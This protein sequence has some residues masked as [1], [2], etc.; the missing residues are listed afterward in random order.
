MAL[1]N[2]NNIAIYLGD[3][4]DRLFMSDES[5]DSL[6]KAADLLAIEPFSQLRRITQINSIVFPRQVHGTAGFIV[7]TNSIKPF[8]IESDYSITN[9]RTIGI[10]ILTADCLP[11]LLHDRVNQA[12]AAIHAGWRGSVAG[13]AIKALEHM[14]TSFGTQPI[15]VRA[16]FG[17]CAGQCCYS[18]G[19]EVIQS[20]KPYQDQVL[21]P[22]GN[23]TYFDLIAYNRLLLEHAGLTAF[24]TDFAQC[25]ICHPQFCSYRRQQKASGRQMTVI[26]LI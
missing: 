23:Q 1:Y 12:I 13:I 10:G 25:T 2:D 3:A 20:V 6:K 17:P 7:D 4:S 16:F 24:C 9:R 5:Y 21:E 15:H 18:V 26:N 8:A 14:K 11:I 22:R 19:P